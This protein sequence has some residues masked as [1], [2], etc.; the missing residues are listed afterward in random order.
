MTKAY[1]LDPFADHIIRYS[2][3]KKLEPT[4]I[5]QRHN[6]EVQRQKDTAVVPDYVRNT[7]EQAWFETGVYAPNPNIKDNQPP[8]ENVPK[9]T[10]DEISFPEF[11]TIF[12]KF[13]VR[14]TGTGHV[15][16]LRYHN[17]KRV[18]PT[19]SFSSREVWGM[20]PQLDNH[21]PFWDYSSVSGHKQGFTSGTSQGM[22][23][24]D[25][26]IS[27]HALYRAAVKSLP[28]VKNFFY[29]TMSLE[30]M[31][32]R[33]RQRFE[34]NKYVRDPDAIRHL[35][36]LG[37]LDYT[38][39]ICFRK[40]KAGVQK[41]FYDDENFEDLIK[42]YTEE[43]GRLIDERS[44]WNGEEQ[45]KNGPY[46]GYWSW[47]GRKNAEEFEKLGSRVPMSWSAGKG[48][49][50][51]FKADGTNYWEKNLDYEGWFIKN[52]DP[53]RRA[54]RREMQSWVDAGYTAPKHYSSKNRRG[55]R[56]LVKDI[57]NIMKSTPHEMYAESRE[58][59]FQ[60][61]VR[62][63]APESNRISAEKRLAMHDDDVFTTKFDELEKPIKQAM[64]EMPNPRLWRTDAFY[65][66]VRFLQGFYE[67]NWAKVP[68]GAAFDKQYN[69]WVSNDANY[70]IL[71]SP[72]FA[73]V[74][75]DK[76][77]NPMAKTWAD[78]YREYDPD[79]EATRRLPWYHADFN[80][81]RRYHWDERCMRMKK[82]VESGDVDST[83]SFFESEVAKFEQH[84]NRYE[85]VKYPG[86]VEYKYSAPRYVQLYRGLQKRMDVGIVNQMR[87]YLVAKKLISGSNASVKEVTAALE[88]C[89]FADFKFQ[90]PAAIYPD[91]VE[92]PQL[93]LDGRPATQKVSA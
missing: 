80:Y 82:W 46:D 44:F 6:L 63:W 3:T 62:E 15:G 64:R 86:S 74:K 18:A 35:L 23:H 25:L 43:E 91:G 61:W 8:A 10:A 88:K 51:L 90:V 37:W 26:K 72:Q 30:K 36:A 77:R 41:F 92:Q 87:E 71:A 16:V 7:T 40:T 69:D 67:Y 21:H 75:A 20:A 39:C 48:Y 45:R 50:E 13:E 53:D 81:D 60:F 34:R 24:W 33:V 83:K 31:Q 4:S 28:L 38:E 58:L 55:Y 78:F 66:R 49:F 93:E 29:L 79:V 52:M 70:T 27:S 57:E 1:N 65:L 22:I 56:R 47:I 2:T 19:E 9:G 42:S 17:Y 89:D 5:A 76:Q 68:I 32:Q 73:A 85:S 59:I 12:G 54:A 84:I 14:P 11:N